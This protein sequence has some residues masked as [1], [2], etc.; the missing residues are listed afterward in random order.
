MN[1]GGIKSF[2]GG[3]DAV[4]PDV[5]LNKQLQESGL[6]QARDFYTGL[7]GKLSSRSSVAY[8]ALS[9]S[10][11]QNV[12]LDGQGLNKSS[13]DKVDGESAS[14]PFDFEEVANNVM[15]FVG[16]VIRG[17][18]K[19][20]TDDDKLN[21]LFD[22]AQEGIQRGIGAAKRDLSGFMDD[23]LSEGIAKV[24]ESLDDRLNQLKRE[25]F[26]PVLATQTTSGS[27]SRFE[28]TE[29]TVRT[30]DGDQISLRFGERESL[31]F[32]QQN[33]ID[34][35]NTS[36]T[37]SYLSYLQEIGVSFEVSGEI[38]EDELKS[39]T[40]LVDQVSGVADEFYNGDV[41]SAFQQALEVGYD[42]QELASFSLQLTKGQSTSVLKA[43]EDV[44]SFSEEPKSPIDAELQS[45]RNY[46]DKMLNAV[47]RASQSL[48]SRDDYN[49]IVSGIVNSMDEEVKTPDL[50]SAINRFH[51]FNDN[52]IDKVETPEQKEG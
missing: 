32:G 16:R 21:S 42:E 13:S 22:Q 20:G 34:D 49:N 31:S 37:N 7:E 15:N 30:R 2:I 11:R 36:T 41:V 43:Y 10:M 52:I 25:I 44:Q 33:T 27:V 6:R 17:A 28:Q 47:D 4:K 38:D 23:E 18:A 39:I 3:Q 1:I 26:Q 9:E 5:A 35:Q 48:E 24:E 40:E 14:N 50:V 51:Q 46:V 8:S 19:S 12:K 29:F 45:I